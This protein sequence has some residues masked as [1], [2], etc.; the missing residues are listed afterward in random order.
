ML[1]ASQIS[2]AEPCIVRCSK[3]EFEWRLNDSFA[4]RKRFGPIRNRNQNNSVN[5]SLTV[6]ARISQT[7][8]NTSIYFSEFLHA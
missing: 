7:E 4:V 2:L 5:K 3:A 1:F 8:I 6:S